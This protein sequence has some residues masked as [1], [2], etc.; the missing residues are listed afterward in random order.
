MIIF[1][2]NKGS[3]SAMVA[4]KIVPFTVSLML[5][6]LSACG[7][8]SDMTAWVDVDLGLYLPEE[9]VFYFALRLDCY[10]SAL[11]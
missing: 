10:R 7:Y 5:V 8:S 9:E 1:D 2:Q 4:R 11:V 3:I 6:L